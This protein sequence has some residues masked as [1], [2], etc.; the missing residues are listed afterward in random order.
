[1]HISKITKGKK[2]QH[3]ISIPK[4]I[5]VEILQRVPCLDLYETL[6]KVCMHWCSI[7]YSGSFAYSHIERRILKS[8]SSFSQLEAVVITRTDDTR[9]VTVSVLDWHS[10]PSY[11]LEY[12]WYTEHLYTFEDALV[13]VLRGLETYT[14]RVNSVNGFVCFWSSDGRIHVCNP[15]TAEYVTTPVQ[16][17]NLYT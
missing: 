6:K 15:I 10:F 3:V 2:K 9:S 12:Y 4:E 17:I 5:V 7:I 11:P 16:H 13:T 14:M 1:M 8:S